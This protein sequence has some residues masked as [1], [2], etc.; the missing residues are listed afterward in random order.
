[1][2]LLTTMIAAAWARKVMVISVASSN[3]LS[4]SSCALSLS[5]S[6]L[7]NAIETSPALH[8][9]TLVLDDDDAGDHGLHVYSL[10][11]HCT[12]SSLRVTPTML[13]LNDSDRVRLGF[14]VA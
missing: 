13:T 2:V 14:E 5:H 4:L 3:G 10:E 12:N 1:M 9:N 7:A 11:L 8:L 6:D